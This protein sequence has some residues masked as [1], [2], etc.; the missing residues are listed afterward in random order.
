MEMIERI[1]VVDTKHMICAKMHMFPKGTF[2]AG[3]V[4]KIYRF[5]YIYGTHLQIEY[6]RDT[7]ANYFFLQSLGF[8]I[9]CFENG[10]SQGTPMRNHQSYVDYGP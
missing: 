10:L 5:P 6:I 4:R 9:C 7:R 3:Y 8:T 1:G 2:S